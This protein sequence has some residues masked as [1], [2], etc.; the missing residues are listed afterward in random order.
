MATP[1]EKMDALKA[2]KAKWEKR[3]EIC[4]K[5]VDD[6]REIILHG[7]K[8][9]SPHLEAAKHYSVDSY[10]RS[11]GVMSSRCYT[12]DEICYLALK[13]L[14]VSINQKI[15]DYQDKICMVNEESVCQAVKALIEAHGL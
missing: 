8:D 13:S 5:Q 7:M 1:Q 14:S 12:D 2:E 10:L 15:R 4:N 6:A 9:E 11:A 3:Y